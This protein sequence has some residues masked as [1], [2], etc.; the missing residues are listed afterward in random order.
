MNIQDTQITYENMR[1]SLFKKILNELNQHNN[2][3]EEKRR[4]IFSLCKSAPIETI[5]DCLNSSD[6][7]YAYEL[8]WNYFLNSK[9]GR[10]YILNFN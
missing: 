7:K 4:V 5:K 6:L 1:S 3:G 9:E 2:E 8:S 10:D